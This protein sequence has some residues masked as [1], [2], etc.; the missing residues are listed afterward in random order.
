MVKRI[1]SNQIGEKAALLVEKIFN[2]ENWVCNR[3][4]H[5]FGI[6]LHVKVFEPTGSMKAMPW[7][8]HVQIKGTEHIRVS[9][10]QV[11]FCIDTEHVKDWYATLLP[12]LFVI[13]DVKS[14]KAY[15]L[16][17]K[18]YV[19]KLNSSWQEQS[20]IT[21]K[22]PINH[23]LKAEIPSQ[24]VA[25]I[26]RRNFMRDAPK[27]IAFMEQHNGIDESSYSDS[28]YFKKL[29]ELDKS[30]QNP[31]LAQC[32]ACDNYFWIDEGAAID[33]EFFK[34]YEPQ[35]YE[36][37]VYSCDAPEEFCP[38]CMSGEGA[39]GKCKN[40]G[41][42]AVP[43]SDEIYENWNNQLISRD[44]AKELCWECFEE[45][46]QSGGRKLKTSSNFM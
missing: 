2:D 3:L 11:I 34:C 27:I 6:D 10:G 14:N 32:V 39:L 4:H 44:E 13:C 8:F 5:D 1:E 16:W 20:T 22:I 35:E 37:A 29:E 43:L 42:Y 26:K 25:D 28:P 12:V 24:L 15:W 45:L 41:R 7:E 30:I 23:H 33:W 18:E 31:A 9:K 21:L 19:D 17:I 38:I 40:C 36:P 46:M